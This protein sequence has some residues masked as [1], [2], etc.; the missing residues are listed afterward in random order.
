MRSC[1]II[2]SSVLLVMMVFFLGCTTQDTDYPDV[3]TAPQVVN[4][5][6]PI[7]TT[8]PPLVNVHLPL[9]MPTQKVVY[10][11]VTTPVPAATTA[12]GTVCTGSEHPADAIRMTGNVYGL[13]SDP[14]AGIDEIKFTIGLDSC[15]QALDLTQMRIVFSTPGTFPQPL[16]YSTRISTSFF[17]AKSGTTR[18]TSLKPGEQ[19][20]IRFFVAPV[21]AN[22]RM[23]I[24]L[25]TDGGATMPIIKTAPARI[26]ATN[27]LL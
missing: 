14:A 25:K 15:S 23:T 1:G 19:A 8:A 26:S 18:I 2:F 7:T 16:M 20:D 5:H 3:T 24:E 6:P 22:T 11:T 9:A 10:V 27:V 17:T 12:V 13:S 21:P 4:A